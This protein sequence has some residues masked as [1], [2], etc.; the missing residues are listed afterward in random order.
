[1]SNYGIK[2]DIKELLSYYHYSSSLDIFNSRKV[3]NH[4]LGNKSSNHKGRGMDFEEV[5]QYQYGDDARLIHWAVSRRLGKM[6][7]KVYKEEKERAIYLVVDQSNSM[8]FGTRVC[9]KNV[10]A[11][12]IASF[13]G[14]S[15]LKNYEQVGGVIFNDTNLGFIK[16]RRSRNSLL[17]M[18][19]LIDKP[20]LLKNNI[21][22]L[23]NALKFLSQN[24]KSGSVVVII[25]DFN[26]LTDITT[27]Y[28][29]QINKKAELI[30]ILTYD[31]IEMNLPN[32]ARLTFSDTGNSFFSLT[33]NNKNT[34]LYTQTFNNK[35]E[36]IKQKCKLATLLTIATNDNLIDKIK[37]GVRT[38]G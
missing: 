22:G 14:F 1:M 28:I 13:I 10:L 37:Y 4:T 16:P 31:P 25:S 19:N 6:Y 38:Y 20:D 36:H 24:V 21:G 15:A 7:T 32:N 23:E 18:F 3:Q 30:N 34:A 27:S 9:F 26:E 17:D 33:T 12:K 35:V 29:N 5:R 11:A 8:K 2:P